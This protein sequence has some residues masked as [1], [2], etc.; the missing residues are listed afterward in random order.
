MTAN[1]GTP[2][3]TGVLFY[4]HPHIY[5]FYDPDRTRTCNQLIKSQLLCQIELRGLMRGIIP[6]RNCLSTFHLKPTFISQ[7][8]AG[9]I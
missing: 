6:E 7:N 8:I 5:R 2:L 1:S 3:H 4:T 9:K